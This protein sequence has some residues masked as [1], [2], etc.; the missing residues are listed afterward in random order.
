MFVCFLSLRI[1]GGS[2][3]GSWGEAAFPWATSRKSQQ[4]HLLRTSPR[5]VSW[6]SKIITT[7]IASVIFPASFKK[8]MYAAIQ[9]D[10][11]WLLHM[12]KMVHMTLGSPKQ[13]RMCYFIN[14]FVVQSWGI[15]CHLQMVLVLNI[16]GNDKS[17]VLCRNGVEEPMEDPA[18]EPEPEPEPEPKVEEIKSEAE[19]KVLEELEE[20]AP[21]PAP[22]ESPPNT[23][24]PPKV[25]P[26]CVYCVLILN[27]LHQ[28]TC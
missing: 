22:V 21:S 15:S 18:P 19:E 25:R 23:Q 3:R 16:C 12:P 24:E 27:A 1:R 20:K 9:D 14:A 8:T 2:W 28:W 7:V 6:N 17:C 11:L 4:H 5:H 10:Y 26:M 13:F